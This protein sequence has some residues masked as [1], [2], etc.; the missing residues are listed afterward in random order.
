MTAARRAELR[1]LR[2]HDLRHTFGT[3]RAANPQVDMRRL[4]EWMDHADISTTLRYSHYVPRHD[5]AALVAEAFAVSPAAGRSAA[6]ST[7]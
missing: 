2:F 7:P 1:R 4:Q 6:R 5:D 3:T